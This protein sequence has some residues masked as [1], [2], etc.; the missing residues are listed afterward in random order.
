MQGYVPLPL[1]FYRTDACTLARSCLG[2]LLIRKT[3]DG[4]LAG[5]ISETEAYMGVTDKASHA[6]GGRRTKRNETMYR[7]AGYAYVYRIYGL[8]CCLNVTAA[9]AGNPEAVLIRSVIPVAGI[10]RM[11]QNRMRYG[12]SRQYPDTDSLSKKEVCRM[13]EGPGR[14]CTA[15]DIGMSIDG[16]DLTSDRANLETDLFLAETGLR[17]QS[18]DMLPRVGIDYAEEDRDKPWRFVVSG[19]ERDSFLGFLRNQ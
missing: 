9:C 5:V 14:L 8:Y 10:D 18:V 16:L 3:T 11:N 15:L 2:K 12:R 13:T 19:A 1:D 4:I 7:D 6:Y 17:V